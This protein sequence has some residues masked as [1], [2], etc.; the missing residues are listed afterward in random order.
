MLTD[1]EIRKMPPAPAGGRVEK[2]DSGY[3]G[4][5]ALYI[6]VQPTGARS[7]AFR[8]SHNGKA[9]KL[10]IGRYPGLGL[11]DARK[12]ARRL[13]VEVERGADPC[14]DKMAVKAAETPAPAVRTMAVVAEEFLR[15]HT[16]AK[17]GDRWS[18]EVRRILAK[19]ILPVIGAKPIAE[20]AKADI[21]DMIDRIADG[22][23]KRAPAPIQANRVLS[24][25]AKLCRW[26]LGRDYIAVDPTAGLPKPGTETKRERVLI[27]AELVAIWRAADGLGY[28]FGPAIK[29][30][31]LTGARR[32]EV[33]GMKWSEIDPGKWTLP[34]S[35]A[36]NKL[37]HI[38]PLSASAMAV[39]ES[40]PRVGH[41][42]LVFTTN[43]VTP[44]S[45]WS[46]AKAQIDRL[47]GETGWVLHD[48]RRCISTWMNESGTDPHIAE[49]VLGH[50]VKGVG[51]V[52]N[53]ASYLREKAEALDLWAKHVEEIARCN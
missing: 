3:D 43:G 31:I 15:R 25:C 48:L 6:V 22:D 23:G 26:C 30:L 20:V 52:Y 14:A 41:G 33:G 53:K 34:A 50:A 36:K 29:M 7:W 13:G 5:G 49:A 28:P 2:I 39:L 21:R 35:R 45:G 38:T 19:D 46:K 42:D 24:V 32:E 27:D 8:Y 9:R 10:T 47:S 11:A 37:E 16:D 1:A 40:V 18:K 51:G 12:E 4:A 17:N 44:V